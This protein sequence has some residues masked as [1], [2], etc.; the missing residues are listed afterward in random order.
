M[1]EKGDTSTALT[2]LHEAQAISPDSALIISE[3]ATTFEKMGQTDKALE[4]WRRIFDMGESAG[5]FYQAADAKLKAGEVA[6]QASAKHD[7]NESSGIQPGSVLGLGAIS[8]VEQSDPASLKKLILKVPL[9]ARSNSSIEVKDVII[10]VFFYDLL[11]GESIVQ[12]NANVASRWSTPPPDWK[13]DDIEVLE[14]DYAQPLKSD[15]PAE[16]RTYFGYVVRVYYKGELQDW[17][18]DQDKLRAK[19]PPPLTLASD[20][21]P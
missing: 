15:K 18:S 10:Q 14:V 12:T 17:R 21:A 3:L 6:V 1:R 9:K 20:Q 13:D 5:I 19:Y 4:Q 7:A 2:R 16:T 8:T 11:G